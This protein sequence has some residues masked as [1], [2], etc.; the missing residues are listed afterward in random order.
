MACK[1]PR[2]E[3]YR[4]PAKA[5]ASPRRARAVSDALR[6]AR[7]SNAA[8]WSPCNTSCPYVRAN[9]L[10]GSPPAAILRMRLPPLA[11][12]S[13]TPPIGCSR[14]S[15]GSNL[16]KRCTEFVTEMYCGTC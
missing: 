3:K 11:I 16:S 10:P 8:R 1:V 5:T 13:T 9:S 14:G 2:L 4:R 6:S 12:L 7:A 15:G